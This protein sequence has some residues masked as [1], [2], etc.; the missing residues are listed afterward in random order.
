MKILRSVDR[1]TWLEV[2]ERCPYATFFQTPLWHDLALATAPEQADATIGAVLPG[3]V[4]AVLP[5]L[6]ARRLGPWRE[7]HSTAALCYGGI[8]ADGPVSPAEAAQLYRA[9]C[10]WR[11][12]RLRLTESPFAPLPAPAGAV[13]QED[14]THILRLGGGFDALFAG[15]SKSQQAH[16]RRGLRRG[17]TVRRAADMDDV[18]AYFAVYQ[19][20]LRRWRAGD[21]ALPGTEE[22]WRRF[23]AGAEL[24]ARHPGQ[25]ALWLAE[26]GG[27]VVS[28]AWVFSWN[29][30]VVYWHG[31]TDDAFF[32]H[33]PAVVLHTEI[34]RE[35]AARG[36]AIYDFN[37]SGG[38]PG[39]A[40]FKRRF[41]AEP[42]PVRR[43][44]FDDRSLSLARA[45]RAQLQA[46]RAARA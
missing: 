32:D 12:L 29:G 19:A 14:S 45:L 4:R 33:H 44:S 25:V 5:L 6:R 8:I 23:A 28:G 21:G 40:E 7:L 42:L 24:A 3:G 26:V 9:A 43:I 36:A 37:P 38:L 15:F 18:R 41:G 20:T 30:H 17:V 34:I 22:P 10:G 1:T 27:R 16:Y 31:A 11:T 39:V 13:V 46:A 2:A 35:A